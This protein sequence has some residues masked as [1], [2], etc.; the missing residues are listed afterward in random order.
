[1]SKL[2]GPERS[3]QFSNGIFGDESQ[4]MGL[5]WRQR[6]ETRIHTGTPEPIDVSTHP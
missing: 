5:G 2:E 1:M 6:A 3:Q 4:D